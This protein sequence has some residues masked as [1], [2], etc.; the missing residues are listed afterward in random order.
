[1][2]EGESVEVKEA[3]LK[4]IERVPEEYLGEVLDFMRYLETRATE[5][6]MNTALAAES[7]L[8]KDW[9]RPEEDEAWRDL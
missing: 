2:K 1:M 7:A 8:R 4:E 6:R 9:L 5:D 3:V